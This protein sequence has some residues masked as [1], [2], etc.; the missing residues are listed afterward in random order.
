MQVDAKAIVYFG[1]C[2]FCS[3][4]VIENQ[5]KGFLKL[6]PNQFFYFSSIPPLPCVVKFDTFGGGE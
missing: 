6:I 4:S 1:F 2:A 3:T 5:A